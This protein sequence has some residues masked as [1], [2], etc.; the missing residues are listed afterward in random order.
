MPAKTGPELEAVF[1]GI[2][3]RVEHEAYIVDHLLD[4]LES[5]IQLFLAEY[6]VIKAPTIDDLRMRMKLLRAV[7]G[8]NQELT[9]YLWKR[10]VPNLPEKKAKKNAIHK[11][12]KGE[13][14]G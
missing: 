2:V 8:A 11:D 12:N 13:E 5:E 1:R 3:N 10:G 14:S 7:L 9:R 6:N 4:G